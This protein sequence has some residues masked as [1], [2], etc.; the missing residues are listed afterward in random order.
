[1]PLETLIGNRDVFLVPALV[2]PFI[3]ADQ[4]DGHSVRVECKENAPRI[5]P[6]LDAKLLHVG[7]FGILDRIDVRSAKLRSSFPQQGGMNEDFAPQRSLQTLK[8]FSKLGI[9]LNIP[10]H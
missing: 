7:E 6:E 9:E 2:A 1:M 4:Q 8:P 5:T 3:S 10:L